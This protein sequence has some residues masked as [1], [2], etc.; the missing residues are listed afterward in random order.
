MKVYNKNDYNKIHNSLI[1]ELEKYRSL[2]N[3][4]PIEYIQKKSELLNQY[5]RK[6]KL[7]TAVI[8]VSGGIDSSLVLALVKNASKLPDSPIKKIVPVAMPLY[9]NVLTNQEDATSRA[10]ELC[11]SLNIELE[12]IP[13]NKLVDSYEETAKDSGYET[14]PW[15][16]GQ[17]GA[18][19]RTS[20]LYYLNSLL[21]ERGYK[22]I[23]VGTTNMDEGC[24]LGYVGKASDGLVDVQLISDIHKSEVYKCSE[25]LGVPKSIMEVTPNG[26]M[27]DGRVDTEVFGAPYDIVELYI[28]EKQKSIVVNVEGEA[29]KEYLDYKNA[30]DKLHNYNRHKY[31]S[32]SP[33]VHLD[34]WSTKTEDGYIDYYNRLPYILK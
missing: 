34:L 15:A 13:I 31:F 5:M 33:A 6:C 1:K 21:N 14:T 17:M 24:Y 8:A 28:G 2:R 7:D 30:L 10:K 18:Y 16:T 22:P 11:E 3:F 26:D 29:E 19:A 9:D 23:L 4:N 27:Y 12:I 32:L 25:I 20:F